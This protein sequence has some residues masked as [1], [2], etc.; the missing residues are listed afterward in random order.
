MKK[1]AMSSS[2]ANNHVKPHPHATQKA[3]N[4]ITRFFLN[5]PISS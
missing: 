4:Y 5:S 3:E 2:I 1:Q